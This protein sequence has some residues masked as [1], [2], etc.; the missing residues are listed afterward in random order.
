MNQ[1]LRRKYILDTV[2]KTGK[3][4]IKQVVNKFNITAM[5]AR[6]DIAEL[7]QKGHLI[8][9]HGGAIKNETVSN[10]FS[11]SKRLDRNKDKKNTIA[12]RA[13]QYVSNNDTIYIDSGTTLIK[14]CP[15]LKNRTGLKVVT[16]SIPAASELTNY[17]GIDVTVIGGKVVPERRS[18]Y[19]QVAVNQAS[20]YHVK[21]AFIGTD[22]VSLSN[23]LSAYDNNEASVSKTI[24]ALADQV[25]LL[26]DSSKIEKDSFYCFAPLA[27]IDIFI[28]DGGIDRAIAQ[29][30]READ[31]NL[32]IT[33]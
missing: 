31:I 32:I 9:T 25:I 13:A 12:K 27:S 5:T 6:R 30:Y 8:R 29:K 23:G 24:S 33:G 4:T 2:N 15:Y 22:G 20:E 28:T 18:I 21:K 3:I 1:K 7:V 26:C 19:G 11:F 14:I 10:L 16:N 17:P